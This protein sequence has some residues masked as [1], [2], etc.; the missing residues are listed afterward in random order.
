MLREEFE[1]IFNPFGW[2]LKKQLQDA[3][4][5]KIPLMVIVGKR[6]LE[7]KNVTLQDLETEEKKTVAISNL[8]SEIKKKFK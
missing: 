1:I 3:G 6:D 7:E 8:I 4:I 5:R 2:N